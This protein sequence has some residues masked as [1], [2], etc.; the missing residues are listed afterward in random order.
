[1]NVKTQNDFSAGTAIFSLYTLAS[2]S[3]RNVN[4][5]EKQLTRKTFLSC[6]FYLYMFSKYMSYEFPIINVCN[7]GVHYETPCIRLIFVCYPDQVSVTSGA[8]LEF[9]APFICRSAG[10]ESD[11]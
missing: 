4:Y 2:L 7:P 10:F 6:S 1:M 9:R 11:A 3:G 8:R 5:D